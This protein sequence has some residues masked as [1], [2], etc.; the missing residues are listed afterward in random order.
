M[1][2]VSHASGSL[3]H[4][5]KGLG[6]VQL[7]PSVS[8]FQ[9]TAAPLYVSDPGICGCCGAVLV[10]SPR[11]CVIA[12]CLWSAYWVGRA[13]WEVTGDLRD[14]MRGLRIGPGK[15]STPMKSSQSID[16]SPRRSAD[17]VDLEIAV[18]R[19]RLARATSKS[20]AAVLS[21]R[22]AALRR[23]RCAAAGSQVKSRF[24]PGPSWVRARE[25]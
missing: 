5:G 13:I 20:E 8:E 17:S 7:F 22:L 25:A 24:G 18:V 12:L 1:R 19:E 10:S 15:S 2:V 23:E 9:R 4:A 6:R 11:L 16:A 21:D 14:V 3:L